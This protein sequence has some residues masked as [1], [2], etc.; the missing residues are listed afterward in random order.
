MAYA[1]DATAGN[2]NAGD[3]H[4]SNHYVNMDDAMYYSYNAHNDD[5]YGMDNYSKLRLRR[6]LYKD[7]SYL[8]SA[9]EAREMR[10]GRRV[11]CAVLNVT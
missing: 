10:R 9:T 1:G 2:D 8:L 4:G 6:S 5:F 11:E 3:N 7:A